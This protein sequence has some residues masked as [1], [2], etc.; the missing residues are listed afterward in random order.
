MLRTLRSRLITAFLALLIISLSFLGIL[1]FSLIENY[2]SRQIESNLN[3]QIEITKKI[4]ESDWPNSI[5]HLKT[6]AFS[7]EEHKS[8]LTIIDNKGRVIFDSAS[9]GKA[10]PNHSNRPEFRQALNGQTGKN[11]HDSDTL[12]TKMIYM[13]KPIEVQ[14]KI[15]GAVRLAIP[16]NNLQSIMREISLFLLLA[17]IL[18][19]SAG[20]ILACCLARHI[21]KPLFSLISLVQRVADG[22]YGNKVQVNCNIKEIDVLST[23]FNTMSEKLA[24]ILEKNK[25]E[26][27]RLEKVL[28]TIPDS[29]IVLDYKKTVKYINPSAINKFHVAPEEIKEKSYLGLFRYRELTQAVDDIIKDKKDRH[30]QLSVPNNQYLDIYLAITGENEEEFLLILIRDI[31]ETKLIEQTQKDFIANVSHELKTPLTSILGFSE[32]LLDSKIEEQEIRNKFL[33]I[34]QDES[35]RLLRLVNDLLSI[36]KIENLDFKKGL[37]TVCGNLPD[38]L[39]SIIN[40]FSIQAEEADIKLC[41]ENRLTGSPEFNFSP[42][43][44]EQIMINLIDN[45]LKYTPAGGKVTIILAEK[46]N[47][48]QIEIHD[49]GSGIPQD[50]LNKIFQRFYRVDKA[51]SRS[52]GG[53]GLGLAIVKHLVE[54]QGGNVWVDSILGKGSTFYFTLP[55][56]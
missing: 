42:D 8:R 53:T 51:R 28:N 11:I 47:Q 12:H 17:V 16:H 31:T 24:L 36:A 45:A 7:S 21:T 56:P 1:S 9:N 22:S 2:L 25:M 20:I 33:K 23:A 52:L 40:T 6:K 43:A 48:L 46:N 32:T 5:N 13:A 15:V 3:E 49:N 19:F 39:Q 38:Y 37:K 34:I 35:H 27:N 41:F 26:K 4:I 44:L 14:H 30:L 18:V 50:D 10:L 29:I 54:I 55:K